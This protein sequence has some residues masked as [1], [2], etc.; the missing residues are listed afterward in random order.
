LKKNQ[1]QIQKVNLIF[2]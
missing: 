2:H 1:L